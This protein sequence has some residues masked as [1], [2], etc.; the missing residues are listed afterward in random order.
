M[1]IEERPMTAVP[2][3]ETPEAT[4][5]VC[6][7]KGDTR[8]AIIAYLEFEGFAVRRAE[9]GEQALSMIG[10]AR[11][12]LMLLDGMM[13]GMD[14]LDVLK[15]IRNEADTADLPVIMVS[16][17]GDTSDVARALKS[18]VTDY[19]VK[20]VQLELLVSRVRNAL[21]LRTFEAEQRDLNV[22]LKHLKNLS[23]LTLQVVAVE[24]SDTVQRAAEEMRTLINDLLDANEAALQAI[25]DGQ[26]AD[27]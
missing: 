20:P 11:P 15:T 7:D 18:G 23:D 21:R 5:L 17:R 1:K 6:D 22:R 16:A 3:G 25:R 9:N 24:G 4:I 8:E 26:M 13:P 14:G 27:S 12:D 19:L 10:D 2:S